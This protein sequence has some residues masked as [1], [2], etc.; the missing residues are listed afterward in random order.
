M[1]G[2]I[3]A[4]LQTRIANTKLAELGVTMIESPAGGVFV[5]LGLDKYEGIEA[6][7]NEDAVAAIRAAIAEWER[8]YTPGLS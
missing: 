2:Q 6:V 5:Y 7:P 3:N 4:I 1:V 8:K